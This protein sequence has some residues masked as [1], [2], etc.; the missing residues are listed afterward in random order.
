M[1]AEKSSDW[2]RRFAPLIREG[3][4][5]LDLAAG[6]GR[7]TRLLLDMGLSVT[8]VDREIAPLRGF[9]GP[10]CDV[11]AFDLETGD[12]NDVIMR[13]GGFHDGIVVTNYLHRPLLRPLA[14]ALAPAGVLIYETFMAG[15]ERLGRPRNPEFLL[16][17]GELLDAFSALTIVAFEQSEVARPRPPMIQRIAAIAGPVAHLPASPYPDSERIPE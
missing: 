10:R 9:A 4:R 6:T 13:L 1:H 8:A 11:R 16:R 3:G 15:N 14:A 7:H 17:P 2:V 12:A 5:V